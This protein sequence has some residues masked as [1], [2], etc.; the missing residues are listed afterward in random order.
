MK[1]TVRIL[2]LV[3]ALAML[4][5]LAGCGPKSKIKG[6]WEG[7]VMGIAIT[8]DFDGKEVEMS[9][10]GESEKTDYEFKGKDLYID[11]D[12]VEYEFKDK[13]TLVLDMEDL[14]K[15]EFTKK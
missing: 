5:A 13:D 14:G 8:L 12:K 10:M 15:V 2:A 9:I 3:M 11:G 1:K 4:L 6:E 7:K